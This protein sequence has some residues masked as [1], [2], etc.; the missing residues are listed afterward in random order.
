MGISH[1]LHANFIN[2][3][4]T[5]FLFVALSR[6]S[7]YTK[8]IIEIKDVNYLFTV[9]YEIIHAGETAFQP[10]AKKRPIYTSSGFLKAFEC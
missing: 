10:L 2:L 9:I 3:E 1:I 5:V 7:R 6:L 4:V 8:L